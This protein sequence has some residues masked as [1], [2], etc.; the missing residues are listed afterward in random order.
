MIK[1]LGRRKRGSRFNC[2]RR[3]RNSLVLEGQLVVVVLLL[4]LITFVRYE[5]E[6][7]SSVCGLRLPTISKGKRKRYSSRVASL[8]VL[9]ATGAN[10]KRY[11]A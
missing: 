2:G 5:N 6:S 1:S 7:C 9:H 3:K 11:K 10:P 4:L 8:T